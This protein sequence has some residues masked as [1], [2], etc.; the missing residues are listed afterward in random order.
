MKDIKNILAMDHFIWQLK[1]L[2]EVADS[3]IRRMKQEHDENEISR[4]L[5]TDDE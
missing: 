1:N 5:Y 2:L 3:V 4:I